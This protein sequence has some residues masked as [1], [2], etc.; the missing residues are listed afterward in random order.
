MTS[1]EAKDYFV[2]LHVGRT[3]CPRISGEGDVEFALSKQQ[4]YE[5]HSLLS[6]VLEDN[7]EEERG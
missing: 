4:A 1:C 3:L 7:N 2:R 6:R 5:L